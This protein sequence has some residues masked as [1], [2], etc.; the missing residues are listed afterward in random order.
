M[1]LGNATR[2]KVRDAPIVPGSI[3]PPAAVEQK[4]TTDTSA[5]ASQSTPYAAGIPVAAAVAASGAVAS[6][7]E[8]KPKAIETP[9]EVSKPTP[10]PTTA[11]EQKLTGIEKL[12]NAPKAPAP[13]TVP[14]QE[15]KAASTPAEVSKPTAAPTTAPTA[16]PTAAQEQKTNGTEK[17]YDASKAPA[18]TAPEQKP[19]DKGTEASKEVSAAP[20]AV[21]QQ[22]KATP[23]MSTGGAGAGGNRNAKNVPVL[24]N[25]KRAWS[26]GLFDC[27]DDVSAFSMQQHL[28]V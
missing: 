20:A 16:A 17:P 7:P 22:P 25:G 19:T 11:E 24:E 23:P 6:V 13:T 18:A 3:A 12:Y 8:Q 1:L 21:S 4:P 28:F 26:F 2:V 27:F 14:K 10:A 15:P 9:A 5:G